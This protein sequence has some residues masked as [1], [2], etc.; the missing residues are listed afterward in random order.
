M[1]EVAAKLEAINQS[2]LA[3]DELDAERRKVDDARDVKAEKASDDLRERM[4]RHGTRTTALETNW[5]AFFGPVG[6]FTTAVDNISKLT[7]SMEEVKGDISG[8][9][10]AS[11]AIKWGIPI[12]IT[13]ILSIIGFFIHEKASGQARIIAEHPVVAQFQESYTPAR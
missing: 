12:I 6:A 4:D 10:G 13:L 11:S 2:L 8:M 7:H 1:A 9:R 5:A 3:R